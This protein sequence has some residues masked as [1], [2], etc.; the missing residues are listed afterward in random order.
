MNT[1]TKN[2]EIAFMVSLFFCL[3]RQGTLTQNIKITVAVGFFPLQPF[4][5]FFYF[6]NDYVDLI[7]LNHGEAVGN[8]SCKNCVSILCHNYFP[9][10]K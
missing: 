6:I 9:F 4:I 7:V 3:Y 8:F 2:R 1:R 10:A 5:L